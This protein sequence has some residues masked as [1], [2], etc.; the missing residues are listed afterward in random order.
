[1]YESG[2]KL[3]NA[4]SVYN[5]GNFM[6]AYTI[7]W[8]L[9][10]VYGL[11]YSIRLIVL[12]FSGFP[13]TPSKLSTQMQKVK[14]TV[15]ISNCEGV[16]SYTYMHTICDMKILVTDTADGVNVASPVYCIDVNKTPPTPTGSNGIKLID[17]VK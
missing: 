5:L 10:N 15:D 4:C 7:P 6:H 16:Y 17:Y 3:A 12:V 14:M 11:V 8:A 9:L 13:S 1:V 2:T